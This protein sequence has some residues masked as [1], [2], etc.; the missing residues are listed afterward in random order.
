[1]I[2][3]V[4]ADDHPVVRAGLRAVVDSHDDMQVVHESATAEALLDWLRDGDTA[5]V[6]LMDLRFGTTAMGGVEATG[7]IVE[8][9]AVPVLVVTMY[10][11][12]ADILAAIESGATGYVLKDAPTEELARAIRSA[13]A[14]EMSF[15]AAV[16]Q[17]IFGRMR[18]PEQNLSARE[19]EVLGL[20]AAGRSNDAIA[21]ELFLSVATVKSHLAHINTK[22]GTQSRTG[23]V[24]VAR[25]RGML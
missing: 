14:G 1:M 18:A 5:D 21:R 13:A 16:Q 12:D 6:I 15:G 19:L 2:D 25:D 22:L 24:A 17:R 10:G 20:V 7:A 9:Y 23:A 11:S 3:V 8:T 4:L